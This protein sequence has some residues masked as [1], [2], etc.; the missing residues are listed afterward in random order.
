MKA[1]VCKAF[2]PPEELVVESMDDPVAGPQ[3]LLVDVSAA[4]VIFPDTLMLEGKYQYS[5]PPPYIPGGEVA[6]VVIAVGDGV[7]GWSVGDRVLGALGATG[8]YAELAAI[9]AAS[10]RRLPESVDFAAAAGLNYAYGT[11][12]YALQHRAALR[13]GETLLI[14]GAGGSVGLSAVEIGKIMGARVIAAAS[15]EEKLDVCR[16]RGAD[17]TINYSTEDL[18]NRAKELTDGKG[19]DVVYDCVGGDYAEQAL[20]AIAW[21]GRFLVIG[22]TAGIPSIPL[23]LTL[24]KS[25]QIVGV[26][27]GAMTGREPAR[28]AQISDQLLE[29]LASGKLQPYVSARY[30]L[31]R[32]GE[33]LRSMMDRTV[34]G[35]VVIVP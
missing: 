27:Y 19:V 25:C 20:R 22:F 23:N 28:A 4:P 2:G 16:Q 11:T 8:G 5:A 26:F 7:T 32:A 3:Q 35:K 18:K 15:T 21:E 31:D 14:L 30:P 33:A 34:V 29:W 10:A 6:G 17:D 9:S 24:L 1:V 12:L 13:E